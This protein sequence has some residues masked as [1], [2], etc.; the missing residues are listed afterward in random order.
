MKA[1]WLPQACIWAGLDGDSV[2]PALCRWS[3]ASHE[4]A[5]DTP[6][7]QG[8]T[9]PGRQPRPLTAFF[10][11]MLLCH[12]A[13]GHLRAFPPLSSLSGPLLF[14][15]CSS[16]PPHAYPAPTMHDSRKLGLAA[17]VK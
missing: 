11:L 14:S 2:G 5:T 9:D 3:C 8:R 1:F 6:C 12:P 16:Y 7:C 4:A 17:E 10:S 13:A 15:P